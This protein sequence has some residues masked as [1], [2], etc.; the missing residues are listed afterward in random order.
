MIKTI[1]KR[2]FA[3]LWF[4]WLGL[5]AN[6]YGDWTTLEGEALYQPYPPLSAQEPIDAPFYLPLREIPAPK[7][8][9][10]SPNSP[11][12]I[13]PFE[14]PLNQ[15]HPP[16][17]AI[18]IDDIGY[19]RQQGLDVLALEGDLTFALIPYA[20]NALTFAKAASAKQREIMLH[21]PMSDITR[22]P[23]AKG[24]LT[25]AMDRETV[26]QTLNDSIDALPNVRGVN[27]HQGSLLT[28]KAEPMQWVMEILKARDLYFVDSRTTHKSVAYQTANRYR[29]PALRRDIFLDH[30][31]SLTFLEKQ[32]SELMSIAKRQG[33]AVAIGHPYPETIQ[34]LSKN[35]S[36]LEANGINLVPVSKI[37]QNTDNTAKK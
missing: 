24:G 35:L 34:F 27:N 18:I 31:R 8:S 6:L 11:S 36:R 28:Q 16:V 29:V 37:L 33:Y 22:K 4:L 13:E 3:C 7:P 15:F 25:M 1:N 32:F 20:P 9:F 23:V 5:S 26:L 21:T 12:P 30:E 19:N 14:K 17:V 2:W 10:S